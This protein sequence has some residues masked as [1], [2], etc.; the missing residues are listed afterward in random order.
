MGKFMIKKVIAREILDS[1]GNPTVEA[2]VYT[3]G[4]FGRASV[5]SGASTGTYEALELRDGGKRYHGKGVLKACRNINELIAQAI[6]GMDSRFFSKIDSKMVHLDGTENKSK[7]GANAILAVSLAVAKAAADTA[8]MPLFQYLDKA[9]NILP[10]P[11]M[12]IINGGKHAGNNLAIQEFMIVPVGANSIKEAIRI[13]SEIYMELKKIL[14]DRY[15]L[16]AIN[17]G[18]E[19]GFAPPISKSVDALASLVDAVEKAGYE[20]ETRLAIDAAASS[21][22]KNG[23]YTVD[24]KMFS[25]DELLDYYSGLVKQYPIISIEDPFEENDY[26]SFALITKKLG[27]RIQIIGDDL[28][29]T[30]MKRFKKGVGMGA[31]NSL[32]LKV[33]QIGTLTDSIEVAKFA[34]K[35]GYTIVVSHRSGETE[36]NYIADLAVA[37]GSGQIKTGAPARGERVCKYNQLLRIEE[38][39]GKKAKYPGFSAFVHH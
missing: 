16:L 33:N 30:S 19:G 3:K 27:N 6:N 36:D 37:L 9:S 32:L 15:G 18:D 10:I 39:L 22:Y 20:K 2:E 4:G 11:L 38:L 29:V 12:N 1:R 8:K 17:V 31:A 7:L 5:P 21:F 34:I 25:S 13:G 35:S 23:A 24:S 14:I 28:F 26:H